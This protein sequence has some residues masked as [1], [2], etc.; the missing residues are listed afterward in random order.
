M[1]APQLFAIIAL[2]A[3][4]SEAKRVQQRDGHLAHF[5]QHADRIAV[6]GPLGGDQS[7]SLVIYNA[8]DEQEAR[9]FIMADPFAADGV[10]AEVRVFAFKASSGAWASTTGPS[11]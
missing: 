11:A 3:P 2:D 8:Q 4:G 7:G 9:D 5:R 6:A 10:W 1:S